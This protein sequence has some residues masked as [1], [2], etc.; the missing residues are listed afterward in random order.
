MPASGALFCEEALCCVE[1]YVPSHKILFLDTFF[2]SWD[3]HN[4][5]LRD[6]DNSSAHT[7]TPS[8]P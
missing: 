6:D 7:T 3:G 5:N 2:G 1:S 8:L 4:L